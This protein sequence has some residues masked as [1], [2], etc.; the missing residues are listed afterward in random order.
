MGLVC[1]M[2]LARKLLFPLFLLMKLSFRLLFTP[3]LPMKLSFTKEKYGKLIV[4]CCW[5]WMR[6]CWWELGQCPQFCLLGLTAGMG[7]AKASGFPPVWF[8]T[9]V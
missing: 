6:G 1:N 2:K 8:R 7:P 5:E 3:F 9:H 4:T